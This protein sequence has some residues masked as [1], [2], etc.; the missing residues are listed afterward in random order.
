[1]SQRFRLP[2]VLPAIGY[3]IGIFY[4]G[5]LRAPPPLFVRPEFPRPSE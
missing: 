5:T 3:T 1:M 4:L 2:R